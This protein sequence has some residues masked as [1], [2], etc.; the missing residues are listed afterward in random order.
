LPNT[1][2]R[3]LVTSIASAA[4]V[5]GG[6]SL[7]PRAH[8]QQTLLALPEIDAVVDSLEVISSGHAWSEGPVWVGGE[9]GYLLFSDVPGNVI[10]QWDGRQSRVF[11]SP[12]GWAGPPNPEQIREGGS[13]GLALGRGGLVI[14]DSGNRCISVIDLQTKSR[15]V[16]ADR[17]EGK[18]FNSPNDVA[19]ARNGDLYLTDPPFGLAGVVNSPLR[20]LSFTGVF[21]ITPDN[22]V[23]LITNALFPNGVALS[24]DQRVLYATDRAGWMAIALDEI[25]AAAAAP[26]VLVSRDLLGGG[27]DGMKTDAHGN[28]WCS[29]PG[30]VHIFRPTGEHIGHIRVEGRTSNC[31]FGPGGFVYITNADRVVRGKISTRFA[32]L[33][34]SAH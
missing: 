16:L 20:E 9:D 30:G 27:G 13:N 10:H 32:D 12:S 14:A 25:G 21:R 6:L 33:A 18:R 8:A 24:P 28:L 19:V 4:L 29:G 17:F 22:H 26:R 5:G 15:T 2:R 1:S 7:A 31:A 34:R 3:S 23:H 11:L